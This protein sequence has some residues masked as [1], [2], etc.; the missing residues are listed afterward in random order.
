MTDPRTDQ[1]PGMDRADEVDMDRVNAT[2]TIVNELCYSAGAWRDY[3]N[4]AMNPDRCE[5][6]R[7][8]CWFQA[9]EAARRVV[10]LIGGIK[11]ARCA[12][13]ELRVGEHATPEAIELLEQM[14]QA[15]MGE[16]LALPSGTE[17]GASA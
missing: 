9:D 15:V 10:A 8:S 12:T 16:P 13:A 5:E 4:M 11:K 14:K 6:D 2:R 7:Q 3:L 1:A 17:A